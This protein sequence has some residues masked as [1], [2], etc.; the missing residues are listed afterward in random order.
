[1]LTLNSLFFLHCTNAENCTKAT[2]QQ[3]K[4]QSIL[5]K[6]TKL[7]YRIQIFF[8]GRSLY[9]YK[10][11]TEIITSNQVKLNK[12]EVCFIVVIVSPYSKCVFIYCRHAQALAA[13]QAY[14]HWLA[15]FYSEVH[16]QNQSQFM[17]LITSAVDA[18]SPL[19]TAKVSC[20]ILMLQYH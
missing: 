6:I 12:V 7:S 10:T 5:Q 17:N 4:F 18:S 16:T 2:E 19:I 11:N 14:S 8:F 20:L 9:I 15:Q 1:M 3:H 13:L